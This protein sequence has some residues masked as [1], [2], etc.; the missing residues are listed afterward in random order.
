MDTS[1]KQ[2]QAS[3]W[4]SMVSMNALI[5][6]RRERRRASKRAPFRFHRNVPLWGPTS[7]S[8]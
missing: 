3:A 1:E 6:G 8:E 5:G 7:Y 4:L 2:L